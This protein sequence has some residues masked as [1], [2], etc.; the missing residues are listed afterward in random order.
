MDVMQDPAP[1]NENFPLLQSKQD[2]EQTSEYFPA[3]Q[4]LQLV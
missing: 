3:V 1:T 2:E 4:K